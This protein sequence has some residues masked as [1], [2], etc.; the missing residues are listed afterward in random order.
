MP[1]LP[2]KNTNHATAL[3]LVGKRSRCIALRLGNAGCP[4]LLGGGGCI[5][6]LVSEHNAEGGG[7]PVGFVVGCGVGQA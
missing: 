6:L 3:T 5:P 4:C 1:L 7:R 2:C